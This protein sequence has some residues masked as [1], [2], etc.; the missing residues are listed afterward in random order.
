M[1]GYRVNFESLQ[2]EEPMPGVRHKFVC[3]GGDKLRLVEYSKTMEPHWCNRGH[4]GM[5]LDGR[6][7]IRYDKSTEIYEPGDGVFI[8]SGEEHRHMAKAL[9]DTVRVVFVED[10]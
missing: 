2:W 7:E 4:L 3:Q 8:P 1:S 10:A 6:F 9:T 5:I